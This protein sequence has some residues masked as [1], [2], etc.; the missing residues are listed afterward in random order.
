M[1]Y[2][3]SVSVFVWPLLN[4]LL[5]RLP[6]MCGLSTQVAIHMLAKY[7]NLFTCIKPTLHHGLVQAN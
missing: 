4:D 7:K 3:V 1:T 2:S 5:T 6:D